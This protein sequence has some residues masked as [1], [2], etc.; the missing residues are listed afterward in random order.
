[1]RE[2]YTRCVSFTTLEYKK[3]IQLP[4]TTLRNLNVGSMVG[5]TPGAQEKQMRN[6]NI[7]MGHLLC[8]VV[9]TE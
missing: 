4:T 2:L 7:R 1:M 9:L 5:V 8:N 3:H 6:G